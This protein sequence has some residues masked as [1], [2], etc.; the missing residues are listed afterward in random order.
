MA[1][2]AKGIEMIDGWYPDAVQ[3]PLPYFWTGHQGHR[4]KA[5]VLHIAEGFL[6]NLWS[7]L[8]GKMGSVH[9]GIGKDGSVEQ[10]VSVN[11][12]AFGNGLAWHDSKWYTPYD[13]FFEHPIRPPWQGLIPGVNPNLYTISIEHE[14]FFQQEW[15][16]AMFDANHRLLQWLAEQFSL[17]Y[18]PQQS[19]IGHGEIDPVNRKNCPG[20]NVDFHRIA[21]E[22]NGRAALPDP[23]AEACR[24][25]ASQ[26][27]WL[28]IFTDAAL[29]KFA[30]EKK[31]GG[32]QTDEFAFFVGPDA[33]VGQVYPGG[34]VCVR[35][36]DWDHCRLVTQPRRG[37]RAR[38]DPVATAALAAVQDL[39]PMPVNERA[40]LHKF[41]VRNN[42]GYPQ[43]DEFRFTVDDEEHV[44]QVFQRAIV[45]AK[46]A[47][48]SR[49]FKLPRA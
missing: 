26:L 41:A 13:K 11:H 1:H 33:H 37:G 47:D 12:S 44:G 39:S 18:V 5:V 3:K 32:P 23:V 15:T 22:A 9:F 2:R 36:G 29:F 49:I 8:N 40:A 24:T 46:V 34:I 25:A 10:Y 43:V 6:S 4:V 17:V 20:P 45:F 14:G 27:H 31:L 19:L 16:D 28:A 7:V 30:Q 48:L 35:V 42:L 21:A 38:A